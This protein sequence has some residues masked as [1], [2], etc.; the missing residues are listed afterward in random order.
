MPS[1]GRTRNSQYTTG[2]AAKIGRPRASRR[3][4]HGSVRDEI[5][6]AA[7][8][9]FREK[10]FAGT[11]T[12]D[13]ATAAG[14]RQPS[15][16]HYFATKEAI[17]RAVAL[18]AVE[19]VLDYIRAEAA[20]EQAPDVALYRLIRFDTYHLCTNDNAMGS[21]FQFPELR[22]DR[23]PEFWALRDEIVAAY[24]Q[25]LEEGARQGT[26]IVDDVAIV[27]QLLFALAE[28]TLTWYR[29]RGE[30]LPA[31][32]VA[33]IVADVALRAVLQKPQRLRAVRRASEDP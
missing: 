18:G 22:R 3:E 25:H 15:L 32:A 2:A 31:E 14:L 11:S 9:L 28:S 19:P 24:R 27:T 29:G 8:A 16:F 17:L 1:R 4:P 30:R 7:R 5:L 23:L 10:G 26:L 12:R 21:P 20:R 13:I 6:T 33:V